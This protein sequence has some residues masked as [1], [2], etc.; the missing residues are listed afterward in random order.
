MRLADMSF[1]IF[2]SYSHEDRDKLD[3]LLK[4]LGVLKHQE[5]TSPWVD[6]EGI[7]IGEDWAKK[8]EKAIDD[9]QMA[10]LLISANFLDSEYVREKE[11]PRLLEKHRKGELSIFPI[12]ARDCAWQAVDWLSNIQARPIGGKPIWGEDSN[13]DQ[14]LGKIVQEIVSVIENW[15]NDQSNDESDQASET[16]WSNNIDGKINFINRSRELDEVIKQ[17]QGPM[18]SRYWIVDA[19]A[20]FGKTVFLKELDRRHKK[21]GWISIFVEP[22]RT[23]VVDIT[24]LANQ[25]LSEFGAEERVKETDSTEYMGEKVARNILEVFKNKKKG[26]GV[27]IF[28][29][30]L[31]ILGK[32]PKDEYSELVSFVDGVFNGLD[33]GG[34]FNNRNRLFIYL[35][36]RYLRQQF[37]SKDSKFWDLSLSTFNFKSVQDTVRQFALECGD[38]LPEE[39]V[40]RIA[41]YLMYAT[42][43]HPGCMAKI[44]NDFANESFAVRSIVNKSPDEIQERIV[45]PEVK[46]IWDGISDN[47][48]ISVL[49]TL[50]VFRKYRYWLLDELID[51]DEIVFA[52]DA[53]S[54]ARKLQ[55]TYL[56]DWKDGFLQDSISRRLLALRLRHRDREKFNRLCSLGVEIH[57]KRLLNSRHME[58]LAI[59]QFYLEVQQDYY[60]NG[61]GGSEL[62][63]KMKQRINDIMAEMKEASNSDFPYI[64]S[65]FRE[66]LKED[67]ELRFVCNYFMS[68]E[69]YNAISYNELI[70]EV[71]SYHSDHY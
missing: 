54:L 36:G 67:W 45:L 70:Q 13:V 29:D 30:N 49:E 22:P 48:L 39:N 14:V 37:P 68:E 21:K 15:E 35:A 12:I 59:E 10:I 28:I 66:N 42:E 33:D 9:A 26:L 46:Q 8:I 55:R 38:I 50:S 19:P 57:Q 18:L 34:F 41:A 31:E 65:R 24:F 47:Y 64:H 16:G 27:A 58:E 25:V 69:S 4:H 7:Q 2:V 3:I 60:V 61:L 17:I 11:V 20:G 23:E 51:A 40:S 53:H 5:N 6:I 63:E 43:G 32:H 62:L 44:L 52:E 71:D 56:L 1:K